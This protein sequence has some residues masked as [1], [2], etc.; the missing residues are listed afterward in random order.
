MAQQT[1]GTTFI[2]PNRVTPLYYGDFVGARLKTGG[3]LPTSKS[4]LSLID[5]IDGCAGVL[6]T[7]AGNVST[8]MQAIYASFIVQSSGIPINFYHVNLTSDQRFKGLLNSQRSCDYMR[9]RFCDMRAPFFIFYKNGDPFKYINPQVW[10]VVNLK[11]KFG[12]RVCANPEN[13]PGLDERNLLFTIPDEDYSASY[14]PND[15]QIVYNRSK[16]S[17]EQKFQK[18]LVETKKG[19]EAIFK[20][21]LKSDNIQAATVTE[22]VNRVNQLRASR[23]RVV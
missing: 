1:T 12:E 16:L 13:D 22:Q 6:F 9:G 23:T 11:S 2:D 20:Q 5:Y 21:Q 18:Q 3:D 14:D 19:Q 10:S 8:K 4:Y 15:G 17:G 7:E